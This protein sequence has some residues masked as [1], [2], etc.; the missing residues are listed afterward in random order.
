MK[1]QRGDL[2]VSFSPKSHRYEIIYRGFS[3]IN[4]GRPP[5]VIIRQKM[6]KKYVKTLRTLGMA[7]QTAFSCS[8][9]RITARY[10]GFTAFGRRL[11]F[12]L[13]CTAEITGENT[14]E[15]SVKAEN[16]EGME[17]SAVYF[18]GPFN[19]KNPVGYTYAVDPMRQGFLMPDGYR[20][21]FLST[22]GF[23]HYL[24]QI[25][26]G[27]CYLPFWGRVS[28]R[29]GFCAIVETPYDAAM[30]SC[31]GRRGSFLNSVHWRSS[32]GK[33]GYE[34]K[35]RFVFHDNCDYNTLA[36]DYRAYLIGQ[37]RLITMQD[38]IQKNPNIRKVVG[39]PVLHCGIF[40]NVHPKSGFY[41][42]NGQNRKLVA[43]FYKRMEQYRHLRELRL[44]KLYI[45]TDG[46]GEQGYDNNHP[47]VL[48]PCPEAGGYAGMRA[49]SQQCRK[50]G[51]VFAIHDQYRDFYYTCKKFDEQKAVTRIDGAHFYNE[52]WAGGPH[53]WL[54]ASQAP[55]FVRD[56]Y[57]TLAEHGVDIQ[58]AYLDV[59]S[60]VAGDECFHPDHRITREK[61][62][63]YRAECFDL[64]NERGIIPSSEEPGG[65]LV[66]KL[67]LVH[68]GPYTLRPQERGE[69]VGIPVP[70]L[71]LV[72]HDCIMI[73]WISKG[74]GGWGIPN[75]DSAE[76]Y[77]VLNAGMPYFE[78][79][80]SRDDLLPDAQLKEEIARVRRLSEIQAALFD[81]EMVRHRFLDETGRRQETVYADGT[82][83]RVDFDRGTYRV[84][85]SQ[86]HQTVKK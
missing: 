12:T 17:I 67:A 62:I 29:N 80:D 83:I 34:R 50:L 73:P 48:P 49:L 15:F 75:G 4:E 54:C 84:I 46:W 3:W 19:A 30:F 1:I 6:G 8:G 72:Y 58:G 40:S 31:F 9:G 43:S 70:L 41:E 74:V 47:Y 52:Y 44:D 35:I 14:V 86:C 81:Q 66:D 53:T 39:S 32:L 11:P 22:F 65:L 21:N 85:P 79:L 5:Y 64:L 42:K 76:L 36:K 51:Y 69:A 28:G 20:K 71:S 78:P 56:T 45:H 57:D 37:G 23:A 59:F 7:A 61:S 16:E 82:V 2:S 10:G 25:N 38:K 24:R 26:T 33:L 27:D 18:P 13:V 77:C 60:I 68:H 55:A 63:R